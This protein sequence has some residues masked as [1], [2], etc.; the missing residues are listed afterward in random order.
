MNAPER[1]MPEAAM[2]VTV[3]QAAHRLATRLELP[4]LARWL[5][6][7]LGQPLVAL[8]AGVR[9]PKLVGKWAKGECAPEPKG[10]QRLRHA[11][12]VTLLLLERECS[13]TI[14]AWFVGMNPELDD[15][16]PALALAD[17]P[18]NVL[19][20]ARTFLAHG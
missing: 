14:R 9:D 6:D 19:M 2:N 12:E 18:E 5:Q 20:A 4:V 8:I 16:A 11:F 13:D 3:D 7:V 15:H 17:D 1:R 10:E